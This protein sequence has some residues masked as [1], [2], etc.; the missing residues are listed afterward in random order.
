MKVAN[1]TCYHIGL[2]K[3]K[4]KTPVTSTPY[5]FPALPYEE[6]LLL[7]MGMTCSFT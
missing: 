3:K 6:M 5:G 1:I 2:F 4:E 7:H